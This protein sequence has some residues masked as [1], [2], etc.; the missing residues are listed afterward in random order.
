MK[1]TRENSQH[2]SLSLSKN[3]PKHQLYLFM[4]KSKYSQIFG[5]IFLAIFAGFGVSSYREKESRKNFQ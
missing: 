5:M 4:A 1:L 3:T 2:G